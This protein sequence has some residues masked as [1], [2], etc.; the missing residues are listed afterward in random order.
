MDAVLLGRRIGLSGRLVCLSFG[1]GGVRGLQSYMCPMP[2][3]AEPVAVRSAVEEAPEDRLETC[4]DGDGD[5]CCCGCCGKMLLRREL[6]LFKRPG[7][8]GRLA[9]LLPALLLLQEAGDTG[10]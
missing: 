9:T 4:S 1:G 6:S 3:E 5:V 2:S 8:I 7:D 10:S